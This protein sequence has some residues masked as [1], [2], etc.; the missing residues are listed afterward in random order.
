VHGFPP[1]LI[2]NKVMNGNEKLPENSI[3]EENC[4]N[5]HSHSN[6]KMN[7]EGVGAKS[8]PID[9][10]NWSPQK[11]F[12]AI[13]TE[14][15][16]VSSS[17]RMEQ[18]FD[19]LSKAMSSGYV[20][21]ISIRCLKESDDDTDDVEGLSFQG[22]VVALTKR[23]ISHRNELRMQSL[24]FYNDSLDTSKQVEKR[25]PQIVIN[26]NIEAVLAS[27]ADGIHVKERNKKDIPKIRELFER[28]GS[29]EAF[30]IIGTSCHS[31]Q[32]AKEILDLKVS[33]DKVTKASSIV[34]YLF[35]G[36]CYMTKSHPEKTK[37]DDLE[38]PTL[39]GLVR[40]TLYRDGNDKIII[41]KIFAIGGI[42]EGNC[43][44]PVHLGADGVA[45]IRSVMQADDPEYATRNMHKAMKNYKI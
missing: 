38:G 29:S 42:S 15:D 26:D 33:N 27:G 19:A 7:M 34:D 43:W 32:S 12:L 8:A 30:N 37:E 1:P 36:T 45:M 3:K 35:V 40:E 41:P 22:R 17:I 2:G 4:S 13:I 44:E 25:L 31:I 9:S 16:A 20:D 24:Q 23:I 6:D 21:L 11:P 39:P 14:T 28:Q 10:S 5:L 18:T